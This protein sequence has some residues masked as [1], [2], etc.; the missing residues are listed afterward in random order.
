MADVIEEL[1]DYCR[2]IPLSALR[3][4]SKK[5]LSNYLDPEGFV[6]GDYSNDWCGLAEKVGYLNQDMRTFERSDS[7]TT[8]L[9]DNWATRNELSPTID[10]L[11]KFLKEIQRKDA[12][13][14]SDKMIR[15]DVEQYKKRVPVSQPPK[16]Q[17]RDEGERFD[18]FV[19]YGD[20]RNDILFMLDMVKILE[21][22]EYN[23]KL[24]VPG[25]DDLAGTERYVLTA[26]MIANRCRR[27]IVVLSKGFENSEYCDFALKLAQSLSPGAKT[28]RIVPI[29]IDHVKV[30]LILNF[31]G[32]VQFTNLQQR[33][34]V[35][36]RVAATIKC[37]LIPNIED[38][39]CTI[40]DL[41]NMRYH[42]KAVAHMFSGL[43]IACQEFKDEGELEKKT[44]KKG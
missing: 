28:R 30:P 39:Q 13:I 36:P 11:I 42:T 22:E 21:G 3:H 32:V 6:I 26:D 1:S 27:V 12:I 17:V 23:I 35:W 2:G 19:V 5:Q 10:T 33:E 29:L 16:L 43:A 8:A 9:L 25:R 38:W 37:P 34:W 20:S 40:D 4:T 7:P 18:A 14:E 31:V 41:K 44:K 15:R 24:F